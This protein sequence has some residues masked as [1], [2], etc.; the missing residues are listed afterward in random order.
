MTRS[1]SES[2]AYDN[3]YLDAPNF[4]GFD[5]RKEEIILVLRIL[6]IEQSNA[7]NSELICTYRHTPYIDFILST[8]ASRV[9]ERAAAAWLR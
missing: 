5:K 3:P 6:R 4:E 9:Q 2:Q 8:M 1:F 7:M